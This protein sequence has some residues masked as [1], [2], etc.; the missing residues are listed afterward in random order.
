MQDF[1]ILHPNSKQ[2]F[3][4]AQQLSKVN[5]KANTAKKSAGL[6]ALQTAGGDNIGVT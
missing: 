2:K 3:H 6:Q 4:Q 1:G 5:I